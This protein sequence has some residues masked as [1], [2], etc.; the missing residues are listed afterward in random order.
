MRIGRRLS[1]TNTFYVSPNTCREYQNVVDLNILTNILEGERDQ[2]VFICH[3]ITV[4]GV[5]I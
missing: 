4:N 3:S 2:Q 1:S 5:R